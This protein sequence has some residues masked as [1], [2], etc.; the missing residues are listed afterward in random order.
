MRQRE[1]DFLLEEIEIASTITSTYACVHSV[2]IYVEYVIPFYDDFTI[3][4]RVKYR[5]RCVGTNE[6]KG[7]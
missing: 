2:V 3:L 4:V 7:I 6:R 5:C 1:Y